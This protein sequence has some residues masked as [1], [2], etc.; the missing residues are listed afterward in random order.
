[1]RTPGSL[2]AVPIYELDDPGD[3]NAPAMIAAF[4]GWVNAGAVG[5]EAAEHIAGDGPVIARFDPD[6]LYDFRVNRPAVTFVGG[7][8]ESVEWPEL[9]L[10]QTRVGDRDLLVL[11]GTEPNWH[12]QQLGSS[13]ADLAA[14]LG[15]VEWV[16]LGGIPSA[17]PHTRATRLLTT[18]SRPEL[19][20][21][22]EQLP[23]GILRVPG[24]AVSIVEHYVVDQ[25]VP[26]VGFW[27]QVPHYV[28]G[29][30]HA[31]VVTLVERVARHCGVTIALGTLVDDAA[32]QREQL[33]QILETQPQARQYVEQLEAVADAQSEMP[34]GEE[35]AA[36]IER[37]LA[38]S[39]GEGDGPFE[40]GR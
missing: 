17:A 38:E 1:M 9:T 20:S 23:E 11:T 10:R 16:S 15:V 21:E 8:T 6:S 2:G 22:E 14:R 5:T 32:G 35:I 27:A 30:Y 33:D 13:V 3:L 37:F 18:A 40:P 31:G 28:G 26:A 36:E 29:T 25:G 39:T 12:W 24:A 7:V 34:S 19:I 4:D